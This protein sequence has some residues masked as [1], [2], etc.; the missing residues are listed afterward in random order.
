MIG[1]DKI[2]EAAEEIGGVIHR[3]P[4]LTSTRLNERTGNEVF[5]KGEHL[6]K[7][8]SFK[9]R[10]ASNK[11][12]KAVRTGTSHVVAA[13][14]G[15]HGQA[16]AYIAGKSGVQATIVVPEDASPVKIS[17]I[18]AYGGRVVRCGLT[19][20]ERIP[21]AFR[22]AEE[23]G[24]LFVPPYDDPDIIAGQ[25]TAG[26]EI[27]SQVPGCEVV[28]VPVG[29]GGLAAGIVCAV[30][31]L[32]P[33]IIVI[34]VEPETADDTKQSLE[35]GIRVAIGP[36]RTIADG[37]RTSIPGELTFPIL[38]NHLDRL[39][40]V[41]D[42]EI[43]EACRLLFQATK[44]VVEPSGAVAFAGLLSG[45]SGITGKKTAAVLSGGNVSAEGF[46]EILKA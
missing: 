14:S 10:G 44:Q 20:A 33:D 18:E 43:A 29:G 16:V 30:K 17:A 8:G 11:I 15:N 38:Q 12:L 39:I 36:T 19:S 6:Q 1:L 9:I 42:E 5:L 23:T 41:S 27:I 31:Q 45:R 13:S 35:S 37:L 28:F 21:E 34:G 22:I 32:N 46:S 24:G 40:M 25:G 4:V 26:M 3:T 2:R 7:T